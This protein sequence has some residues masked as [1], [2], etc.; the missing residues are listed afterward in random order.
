MIASHTLS[1][2]LLATF[3]GLR[4]HHVKRLYVNPTRSSPGS[5]SHR[6]AIEPISSEAASTF[7]RRFTELTVEYPPH[8]R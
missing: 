7:L 4:P 5:N 2:K 3:S 8:F 1:V 6:L